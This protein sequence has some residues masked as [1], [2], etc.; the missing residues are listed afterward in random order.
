MDEI[1][2]TAAPTVLDDLAVESLRVAFG[3]LNV[4]A[5]LFA[6]QLKA[7][8]ALDDVKLCQQIIGRLVADD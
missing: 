5:K 6:P 3:A 1:I 2:V 4:A 8:K 7:M